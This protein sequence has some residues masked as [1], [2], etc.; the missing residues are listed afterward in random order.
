MK[1]LLILLLAALLAASCCAALAEA[2][3]AVV[4]E[5]EGAEATANEEGKF[6]V[7]VYNGEAPV[8]GVA[9]QFCDDSTCSVSKTDAEGMAAFEAPE[10]AAYEVHVLKVPVGYAST[11]A[12]FHTLEVW[13]DVRI[14]LEKAE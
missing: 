7:F 11:D 1:K 12:V 5:G 3:A 4:P 9:I 14:A 8:E 13:S 6:R 2:T 10:G